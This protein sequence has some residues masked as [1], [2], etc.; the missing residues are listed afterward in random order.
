MT[1]TLYRLIRNDEIDGAAVDLA[2]AKTLMRQAIRRDKMRGEYAYYAITDSETGEIIYE[3]DPAQ[4]I[5]S[6]IKLRHVIGACMIGWLLLY[7]FELCM[8]YLA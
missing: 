2:G 1:I 4:R 5:L 3:Y 6:R 7:T 8:R